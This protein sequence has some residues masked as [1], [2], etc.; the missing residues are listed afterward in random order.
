M[1]S[2][3]TDVVGILDDIVAS[4][5]PTRANRALA[6]IK[7][8]MNWCVDRGVIEISPVAHLR[9]PTKEKSRDR[10]LSHAE[11]QS[12]WH[13]AAAEGYPFEQFVQV[14][15]LTGQRRGEV[16]GMRWSEGRS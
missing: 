14:L 4:G 3:A 6:A 2:S 13:V 11:M 8:L 1:K 12:L 10:V 7:K 16:A 5:T 15:M 9:P